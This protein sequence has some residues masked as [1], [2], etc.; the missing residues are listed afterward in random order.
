MTIWKLCNH[1]IYFLRPLILRAFGTR[2]PLKV[3]CFGSTWI[4]RPWDLALDEWVTLGPRVTLYN[5]GHLSISARTILSQ[6][7]YVCGGTHDYNDPKYPLLRTD[8]SI[9]ADVWI[10]AGAFICPGASVGARSVVGARAVVTRDVP[11]DVVV[12]GNPARV[13]KSRHLHVEE[14]RGVGTID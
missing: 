12:G 5:L 10:A 14:S 2:C 3:M 1:R 4:E 8:M 13:L 9:G 7:V 11:P 6:D